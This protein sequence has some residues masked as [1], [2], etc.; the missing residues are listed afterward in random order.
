LLKKGRAKKISRKGAKVREKFIS[1]FF[2]ENFATLYEKYIR[3]SSY[4]GLCPPIDSIPFSD[5]E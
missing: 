2:L 4:G 3:K 5:L 1:L